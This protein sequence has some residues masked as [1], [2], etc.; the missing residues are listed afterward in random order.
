MF[1]IE[2]DNLHYQAAMKFYVLEGLSTT[3]SHR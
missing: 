2:M 3:E 1:F